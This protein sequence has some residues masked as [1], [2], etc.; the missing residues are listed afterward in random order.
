MSTIYGN[1]IEF[2]EWGVCPLE[3]DLIKMS[4]ILEV[5]THYLSILLM[6]L[7]VYQL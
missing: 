1:G 3:M 4:L 6:C 5:H 7:L 2:K